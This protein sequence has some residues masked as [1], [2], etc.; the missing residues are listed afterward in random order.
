MTMSSAKEAASNLG[1]FVR[2]LYA[3]DENADLAT[4][5]LSVILEAV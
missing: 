2:P 4:P 1:M 5:V 3:I